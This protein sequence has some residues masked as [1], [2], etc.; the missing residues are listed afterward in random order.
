MSASLVGSEMCIRDR[1]AAGVLLSPW[2]VVAGPRAS[3][4]SWPAAWRGI[5]YGPYRRH[6]AA[7]AR[8]A[9]AAAAAS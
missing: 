6:A 3:P 7:L 9:G 8:S 2:P 4:G 5:D 1:P